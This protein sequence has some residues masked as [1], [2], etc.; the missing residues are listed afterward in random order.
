MCV[1]ALPVIA[2]ALAATGS[3]MQGVQGMMAATYESDVAKRNASLE[4][5]RARDSIERGR[6]EGRDFYRN[7]GQ[8]KG[9]QTAALAANGLDLG[10]GTALTVQQDT[11]AGGKE[12]V[13]NLYRNQLERTR[14]FEINA[15]NY[16][17]EAAAARQRG[18]AALVNSFFQAGSSLMGGFQQQSAMRARLG[19]TGGVKK[20]A[21]VNAPWYV[22]Y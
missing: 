1:A 4:V 21:S 7:L 22:G 12:D 3:V 11:A 17:A 18:R 10:F 13:T 6:L 8:I 5:D 15:S 14:G 19:I 9:Q 16:R 20:A 2:G